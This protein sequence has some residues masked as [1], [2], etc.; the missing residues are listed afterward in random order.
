RVA[1]LALDSG[2]IWWSRELSSHRGLDIDDERVFV[3]TAG[4]E[5][6]ALRRRTGVEVWRQDAL[7]RR[8][9]SGPAII[10]SQVVV[11]DVEGYLHWLDAE[12]GAF[13]ARGK[14]GGRVT[15]APRVADGILVVQDDEGRVSAFRPRAPKAAK[16]APAPAPAKTE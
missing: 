9:L 11:A 7:R 3:S 16:A 6:V 10:G 8:G 2:Q 13:V 14:A 5:V 1:M 12:T 4:G 15:N